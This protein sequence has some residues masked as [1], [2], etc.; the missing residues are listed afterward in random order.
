MAGNHP[1][2]GKYHVPVIKILCTKSDVK[3]NS[4]KNYTPENPETQEKPE[5]PLIFLS[6]YHSSMPMIKQV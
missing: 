6:R 5:D 1:E 4:G 3:D 2:A